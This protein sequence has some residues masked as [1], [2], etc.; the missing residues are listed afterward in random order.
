MTSAMT[1][2]SPLSTD[3]RLVPLLG[4]MSKHAATDEC[5]LENDAQEAAGRW[6]LV[7]WK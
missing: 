7:A 1:G 4:A 3:Y 6:P 5:Y 2:G